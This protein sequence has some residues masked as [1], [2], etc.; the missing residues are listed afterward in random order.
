MDH[1]KVGGG[2]VL[3]LGLILVAASGSYTLREGVEDDETNLASRLL[4]CISDRRH[5]AA[6]AICVEQ[7][8][9]GD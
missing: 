7:I 1:P 2:S 9:H 3:I 5:D 6:D 8:D 4:F